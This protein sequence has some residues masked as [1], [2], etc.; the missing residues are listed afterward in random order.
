[1]IIKKLD[2]EEKEYTYVFV[3]INNLENSDLKFW[4][5][6]CKTFGGTAEVKIIKLSLEENYQDEKKI[7]SAC[8]YSVHY[9]TSN[10]STS[11]RKAFWQYA[12]KHK[13]EVR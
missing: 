10:N 12:R 2:K 4:M 7:V 9:S 1:M 5:D 11:G 6:R 13:D 8:P 3:D